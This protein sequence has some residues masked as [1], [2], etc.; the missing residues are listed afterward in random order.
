MPNFDTVE[1]FQGNQQPVSLGQALTYLQ[2]FGRLSPFVQEVLR[3]YAIIQGIQ[4]DSDL[5]VTQADLSQAIIDFRLR[6]ELTDPAPFQ[7]WL[8]TQGLDYSVFESQVAVA[9]KLEK[10]KAKLAETGL[11]ELFE[12]QKDALEQVDLYYAVAPTEAIAYELK[13]KIEGGESLEHVARQYP[14]DSE[15]SVVIKR[16]I[17]KRQQL[18]AE[19]KAPAHSAEPQTLVGPVEM[20]N[21]WCLFRIEQVLPAVLEGQVRRDL[22]EQLFE[23]WVA[24]QLQ[25]LQVPPAAQAAVANSFAGS[26]VDAGM[27]AENDS[28]VKSSD[29]G[30]TSENHFDDHFGLESS[31][32]AQAE[33]EQVDSVAV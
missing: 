10:L 25:Q 28:V 21:R 29:N 9:L 27:P 3:D 31:T 14:L 20:G 8:K 2:M 33:E 1:L 17:L 18:R 16:E 19:I 30:S 24:T 6:S 11:N 23:Q 13:A 15:E 32:E 4:S 22:Q 7:A 12:R 5:L 26:G